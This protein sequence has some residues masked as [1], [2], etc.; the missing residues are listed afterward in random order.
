MRKKLMTLALIC[1][2]A[3]AS[4]QEYKLA[5]SSGRLELHLG[6]VTVEG[7]NGKEIVFSSRDLKSGSDNRAEGLRSINGYGLE[8]NTNLGINVT[9][10]GNV[11][12][13]Y[14]L[15]KMNSPD[16]KILVPKGITVAYAFESLYAGDIRFINVESEIE[17]SATY[18]NVDLENVTGPMTVKTIYGSVDA[19]FASSI[20]DPISIVSVYGHV[21]VSIPATTKADIEL[22]T[23][24]GEIL[25]SPEL[26]LEVAKTNDLI[27]VSSD[28]VTGKINGGG[29]S[30]DLSCTYGKVYLRKK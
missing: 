6:R 23:A 30:I 5:K 12:K 8:D 21:D 2:A 22:G 27:K 14:Q 16:I 18:G 7:Y 4:A 20:Q 17:I 9:E 29:L 26:K 13:V 24:H 28:K 10:S 1:C 3:I 19:V 15:K 25:V 11:I